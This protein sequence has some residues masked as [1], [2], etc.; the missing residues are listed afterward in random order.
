MTRQPGEEIY[1]D[2][3]PLKPLT[4]IYPRYSERVASACSQYAKIA[5]ANGLKIRVQ[6]VT[7]SEWQSKLI[8]GEYELA[9]ME[10]SANETFVETIQ[11]VSLIPSSK[12]GNLAGGGEFSVIRLQALLNDLPLNHSRDE[13]TAYCQELA[14]WMLQE[15]LFIPLGAKYNKVA[16]QNKAI[17]SQLPLDT[18]FTYRAHT[19]PILPNE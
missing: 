9:Y 17:Q 19:R 1:A 3:K 14:E 16:L 6:P 5:A 2:G 8:N 7:I 4:L 10:S 13:M 11:R 18:L 12:D 15:W